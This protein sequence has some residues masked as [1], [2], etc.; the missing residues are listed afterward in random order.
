LFQLQL[1]FQLESES[2]FEFEFEFEFDSLLLNVVVDDIDEH[3]I[4]ENFI[5]LMM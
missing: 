3:L 1:Q 5:I 4:N 2:E